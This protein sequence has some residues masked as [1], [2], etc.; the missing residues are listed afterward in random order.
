MI[1]DNAT[2]VAAVT[3]HLTG[4]HRNLKIVDSFVKSLD[5]HRLN[6]SVVFAHGEIESDI[7]SLKWTVLI[8][9][10]DG[11]THPFVDMWTHVQEIKTI[12]GG[13]SF[14]FDN[15]PDRINMLWASNGTASSPDKIV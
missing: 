11:C 13:I 7:S 12:P 1:I 4:L 9:L 8:A 15:S 10:R 6:S 14:S 3:R 2:I 5:W